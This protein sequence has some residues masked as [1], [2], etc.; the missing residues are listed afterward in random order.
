MVL[1]VQER[2]KYLL[3]ACTKC[4]GDL[5]LGEEE[6]Y[7]FQCGHVVYGPVEHKLIRQTSD[8]YRIKS[9]ERGDR[10]LKRREDIVEMIRSK[11]IEETDTTIAESLGISRR[12]VTQVRSVLQDK[13]EI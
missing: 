10:Y 13:G 9:V 2:G 8:K 12:E 1:E 7:C 11:G 5:I 4:G 6:P 3:K